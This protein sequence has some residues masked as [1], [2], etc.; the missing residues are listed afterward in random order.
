V[1]IRKKVDGSSSDI[2][3]SPFAFELD[4]WYTLEFKI[5]GTTLTLSVD[6][7]I[8]VEGTDTQFTAGGVAFLVDRSEVSWDNVVVTVP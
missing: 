7:V 4:T 6:G 2:A 1:Q 8:L 3:E 5:S